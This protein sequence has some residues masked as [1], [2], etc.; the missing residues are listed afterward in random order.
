MRKMSKKIL[1]FMFALSLVTESFAVA[2]SDNDGDAFITRA[3]FDSLKENFQSQ[4][5]H[6]NT[7]I[8]SK[9]NEAIAAYLRGISQSYTATVPP[10]CPVN[11]TT[12]YKVISKQTGSMTRTVPNYNRIDMA[13]TLTKTG[14][15]V[16]LTSLNLTSG[17]FSV[18][19]AKAIRDGQGT[20][21]YTRKE[22]PDVVDKYYKKSYLYVLGGITCIGPS[23]NNSNQQLFRINKITNAKLDTVIPN[24]SIGIRDAY[25]SLNTDVIDEDTY[26]QDGTITGLTSYSGP[27]L[28]SQS[29]TVSLVNEEEDKNVYLF[30]RC[31][32]RDINCC[33]V[34]DKDIENYVDTVIDSNY[35]DELETNTAVCTLQSGDAI[36]YVNGAKLS[37][38]MYLQ[39]YKFRV[40]Q[41][42]A[43]EAGWS[44]GFS[45]LNQLRNGKLEYTLNKTKKFPSFYGGLPLFS[46]D[47]KDAISVSF[48]VRFSATTPGYTGGI[49][50][51]IKEDEFVNSD[52]YNSAEW[53]TEKN[54]LLKLKV[55]G[56]TVNTDGSITIDQNVNANIEL[57]ELKK[58]HTYFMRFAEEDKTY[59]GELVNLS[60][61]RIT[62]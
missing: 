14:S 39:L 30:N 36:V 9:I 5:D 61:I 44:S 3:E 7:S 51:W 35:P 15:G 18:S 41:S 20:L 42:K 62:Y 48:S 11:A 55:K 50:V 40:R 1:C 12:D 22:F 25:C 4:I 23:V 49:K 60:D 37:N 38:G 17:D 43:M 53:S 46:L 6:Y 31:D 24:S 34:E 28:R 56:K 26:R 57:E 59:G 10:I 52:N 2:V 29:V 45:N 16:T 54:K 8:D 33:N 13:T 19:S 32:E 21:F 58:G 27:S 47:D